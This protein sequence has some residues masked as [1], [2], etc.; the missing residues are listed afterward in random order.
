MNESA[1]LTGFGMSSKK[2]SE[3]NKD[4]PCFGVSR[5]AAGLLGEPFLITCLRTGSFR[6]VTLYCCP[7]GDGRIAR[8]LARELSTGLQG[9][10]KLVWTGRQFLRAYRDALQTKTLEQFRA[11]ISGA[12]VVAVEAIEVLA[13]SP[14]AQEQLVGLLDGVEASDGA[15]GLTT[16]LDVAQWGVFTPRLRSRL[17]AALTLAWSAASPGGRFSPPLG[18]FHDNFR[19]NSGYEGVVESGSD[20]LPPSAGP[21]PE[22]ESQHL[23]PTAEG[24]KELA[25]LA[26]QVAHMWGI[27]V[28]ELRGP[29]RH[30]AVVTARHVAM[31]LARWRLRLSF[32]QI[33]RYFGGRDHSTVAHACRRVAAE[34]SRD[35]ELRSSI[36]SVEALLDAEPTL[37]PPFGTGV[38]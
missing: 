16:S 4:E 12:T 25:E 26:R 28:P 7:K 34:L 37:F 21:T 32:E 27:S 22:L 17:A 19:S 13:K 10:A 36:A 2:I 35:L 29:A 15:W 3:L 30:R 14:G 1:Q 6:A 23:T 8:L 9:G 31:Y 38:R 18:G 5:R 11:L 24:I 33:G 20:P